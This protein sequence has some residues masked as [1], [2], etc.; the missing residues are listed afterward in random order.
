MD[1]FGHILGFSEGS[2]FTNRS[3]VKKAG[4][5]KML[6]HGIS[7][8]PG[9]GVVCIVL[10]GG[11]IDDD[12]YGD[13]VVYTGEGGRKKN[14]TKHT[15]NQQLIRGN[16][17]LTLNKLN[18][19]PVRVIRGPK[20]DSEYK[21]KKGYRY[22]GLYK[23]E[24]YWAEKGKHGYIVWRYRLVKINDNQINKTSDEEH[25]STSRRK[26]TSEQIVRNQRLADDIKELY[27]YTCQVCSKRLEAA[28]DTFA[29]HAAHIRDLGKP[30]NGPDIKSNMLCLCLNHHFLYDNYGFS[31]SDDFKLV[32]INGE[33]RVHPDHQINLEF[34]KYKRDHYNSANE[35]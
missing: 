1:E 29:V 33:L 13:I 17:D 4:L 15:F 9:V 11:Y 23:V 16:K 3:A 14:E 26:I 5:H 27:N 30:H 20:L 6:V 2:L 12:D 19:L 32:G 10:N 34:I 22:D 7:R 8:V 21:T 28:N 24:T 25:Q 31:I 18:N 35:K